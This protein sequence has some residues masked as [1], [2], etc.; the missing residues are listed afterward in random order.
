MYRQGRRPVE[1]ALELVEPR[2]GGGAVDAHRDDVEARPS[3]QAVGEQ[4]P[5]P[6]AVAAEREDRSEHAV[7]DER[8]VGARFGR[9]QL[10]AELRRL[11]PV[12]S[13]RST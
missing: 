10:V 12:P 11:R 13:S 2:Q 3:R 4:R 5:A 8:V 1:V 6:R 9:P 7:G